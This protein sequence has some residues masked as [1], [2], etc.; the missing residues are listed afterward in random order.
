MRTLIEQ[1]LASQDI[2]IEPFNAEFLRY[3][4]KFCKKENGDYCLEFP[5]WHFACPRPE[6]TSNEIEEALATELKT[7]KSEGIE[8]KYTD[9]TAK[10]DKL[11]ELNLL[12]SLEDVQNFNV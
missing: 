10:Q 6:F 4:T 3:T 9:E 7:A 12:T 5:K 11:N 2:A 8:N 1:Y